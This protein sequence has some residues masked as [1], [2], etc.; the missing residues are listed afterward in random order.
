MEFG[1]WFR[2]YS[3]VAIRKLELTLRTHTQSPECSS[4]FLSKHLYEKEI[5]RQRSSRNILWR[6]WWGRCT[7]GFPVKQPKW[8]L[9]EFLVLMSSN[10]I[11]N[12]LFPPL[13]LC[14]LKVVFS[15]SAFLHS[16]LNSE[17]NSHIHVSFLYQLLSIQVT[18][19]LTD[20]WKDLRPLRFQHRYS[21][22][23]YFKKGTAHTVPFRR[24]A[25]IHRPSSVLVS[26][27]L[28]IVNIY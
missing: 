5:H 27:S 12:K 16:T 20:P 25:L 28:A 18:D 10:N 15:L 21:V 26:L 7:P 22:N 23:A 13:D 8:L 6:R 11:F 19:T 1:V 2:V 24:V 4:S 9:F 17:V 14:F 3:N